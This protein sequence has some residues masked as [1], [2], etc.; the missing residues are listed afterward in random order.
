M[1]NGKLTTNRV[2]AKEG[3][4][5]SELALFQNSAGVTTAKSIP[6]IV[7]WSSARNDEV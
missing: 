5:F 2:F 7:A 1:D 4:Q 3:S 6:P